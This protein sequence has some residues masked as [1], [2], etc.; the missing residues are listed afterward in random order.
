V[1]DT[2]YK[3]ILTN[4]EYTL[5]HKNLDHIK[6][7]L[8]EIKRKISLIDS[9]FLRDDILGID[10]PGHRKEHLARRVTDNLI[11]EYKLSA[12]KVILAAI[13]VFILGLLS[14]GFVHNL[15]IAVSK[16]N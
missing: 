16:G 10:Y 5:I 8:E 7:E 15:A 14:S 9:A 11:S 4:E 2:Q 13:V 12:T 6:E 1:S 3:Q